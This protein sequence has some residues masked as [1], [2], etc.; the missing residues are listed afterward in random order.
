MS[1]LD[2]T[3][4]GLHLKNPL[5]VSS[6]G[7]TDSV[8]KIKKIADNEA[9]AVI[10]KSLFEEQI[11]YETSSL[12][13]YN[14]YPEAADYIRAYAEDNT[15]NEYIDLIK[16]AKKAVSIP[17]IASINSVTSEN[18]VE[19]ATKLEE[20]GADALELNIHI[21]PTHANQEP[22][23][24]EQRYL[25]IIK[26]VKKRISIPLAVKIG[27]HFTNIIRI[28]ELILA[29][30]ASAITL[31]NKFYEPDIN[32]ESKKITVGEVFTQPSDIRHAL[33][34]VGM[35]SP[36]INGEL[37]ASTGVHSGEA[38][39][40]MLLAGAQTVQ[41]ASI[42]YK[43]GPG[44][45]P[46]FLDFM[47]DWM[48]NKRYSTIDEFRGELNYGSIENPSLYERTQFMKYYSGHT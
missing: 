28:S 42:I 34:W 26:E 8:D 40:K 33:R 31:F 32:I 12:L 4:M 45:I 5:I 38:A 37:S 41:M 30:G 17:I 3:Y 11:N 16:G 21:I 24:I 2:T 18:W 20:A 7:L 35:L 48:K 27:F 13:E 47:Q 46:S 10:L 44:I 15:V 29:S 39:I 43:N 14:D 36:T 19:Y 6:S 23:K 22:D 9:G 25:S 1:K